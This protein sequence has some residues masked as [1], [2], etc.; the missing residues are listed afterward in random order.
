MPNL[1]LLDA[2]KLSGNDMAVGLVEE[3]IRF[4]P[5]VNLFP[6][7]VIPGTS[8]KT[9][10]RTG[11]PETDF[12]AASAGIA[13]GKSTF[14]NRVFETSVLGGRIEVWK[15]VLDAI[16]NGTPEEIKATEASGVMESAMRKIGTQIFYGRTALG[17]PLGFPG[18]V[19]FVNSSMI[20]DA[21]GSTA[22]TGSSVYFVKFGPQDVQMV[23]G[24][25]AEIQL[26]EFRVESL[27]DGDGK[28]G[29]G[30]VADLAAW[31]G[32]QAVS[33][34]SIV[35]I[36]NL[37]AQTGKGLTDALIATALELFP[38]G[39]TPDVILMSRRSRAQLRTSRT[40]VLQGSGTTRPN[41]PTVAPTP[42][43]Y[44]GIPIVATDSIVNVEPIA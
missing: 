10:I 33:K 20:L 1:T 9:L 31:V 42:T 32:L 29:P 14:E 5:E 8:F 30:E 22:D 44:E 2:A 13:T 27:T 41:Q 12:I 4:A 25:N 7:R 35:R 36:K 40:V 16:E 26:S 19:Q 28:K 11:L 3:N 18:L 17:R 15:T 38:S 34:N 6:I 43:E 23:M 24:R 37:T 39:Y 21:T